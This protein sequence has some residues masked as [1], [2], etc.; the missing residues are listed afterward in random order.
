MIA[1]KNRV[2]VL[3]L[4]QSENYGTVLQAYATHRL[5]NSN[6]EE[7][8]YSL[9]PTDVS[10]VR[11]RRLISL[12]NPKNPSSGIT[13]VQNFASMRSFIRPYTDHAAE[14]RWVDISDDNSAANYLNDRF[15]AFVTGSD[16]IWNLAFVGDKSIYYAPESLGKVRVSFATSANRLDISKLSNGTRDIL[17]RSVESYSYISVRDSNTKTLI[18][19]LVDRPILVDEIVDPTIIHGLPEFIRPHSQ[20]PQSNRKRILMMVRDR[21]VG[22]NILSRFQHSAD[23]DTV[24]VR[25]PGSRFL[26]L[27][28]GNFAGIFGSYDCVVTDFFHGTCMSVLSKVPFISFDSEPLYSMY[29]SKISN[30]LTKLGL[31]NRYL[32]LAGAARHRGSSSLLE[33]V[34]WML[35]A[36]PAW[37]A[38]AAVERER[39]LG[40]AALTRVKSTISE[41]LTGV[42]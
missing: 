29:E 32:N 6:L 34:Q 8:E 26:Q 33:A 36:P 5:L 24:F 37:T 20:V 23:I 16:E 35:S 19:N 18:E 10:P 1:G 42:R 31:N 12:V 38:D 2:G 14:R 4:T 11:R 15:S 7:T 41:G 22:D 30:F 21:G 39:E 17:R 40:L 27:D 28:P 25:Y 3:T 9:V 13:R